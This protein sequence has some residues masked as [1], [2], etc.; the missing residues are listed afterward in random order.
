MY[1][2][3]H[4]SIH[5]SISKWQCWDLFYKKSHTYIYKNVN[6]KKQPQQETES[7]SLAKNKQKTFIVAQIVIDGK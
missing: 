3:T 2:R 1:V 5:I 4:I 7:A 6:L